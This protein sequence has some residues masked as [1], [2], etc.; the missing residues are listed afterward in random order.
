MET[1]PTF[2]IFCESVLFLVGVIVFCW[3]KR[4]PGRGNWLVWSGLIVLLTG[5]GIDSGLLLKEPF[6]VKMWMSGWIWARDE[7]GAITVGVLQDALGLAMSVLAALVSG[8][9]L[10]SNPFLA[11]E[12]LPERAYAGVAIST[13]G[14]GVAWCSLTPWLCFGGMILTFLGGF[15]VLG[16]RWH[17]NS[18]SDLTARFVRERFIGFL[19]SFFGACILGTTRTALLLNSAEILNAQASNMNSTWIGS[20]L[21]VTGLFIQMQPFPFFGWIVSDLKV[22][23]PLKVILNQI[24]PAWAAFA[25]LVRLEP[26]LVTLGLFPQFGWFAL[27]SCLFIVASGLFQ[28]KWHVG[29]S[30]WLA[31]GLSLSCAV[32][33]FTGPLSAMGLMVGVSLGALCLSCA[34]FSFDQEGAQVEGSNRTRTRWVRVAAFLGAASGTGVIGFVSATGSVRWILQSLDSSPI[35]AF[36]LLVFFLF[37]LLG[38]KQLWSLFRHP[39]ETNMPWFSILSLYLWIFLA[40]GVLWTGA[41]TGNVLLIPQDRIIPS[42]YEEIFGPASA[43]FANTANFIPASSLYWGVLILAIATAYWTSGRKENKWQTLANWMP[44]SSSFMARGF[45]VDPLV[46]KSMSGM[47]WFGSS[48]ERMVDQKVWAEWIPKFLFFGIKSLSKFVSEMDIRLTRGLNGVLK[49]SVEIPAK[50]LQLIQTGDLRWYLFFSLGS[51]FA[52]L[53]HFLKL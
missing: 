7:V 38:W 5:I 12:P 45:G 40:L 10:V 34:S 13:V 49:K 17:E 4:M 46:Q 39:N 31:A 15:V 32:L 50:V 8:A 22:S 36:F 41:L 16:S 24:F 26:Q 27:F 47:V 35:A 33:A 48:A 3:G 28:N 29:L 9:L 21:L 11:R 19:L 2:F 25:I 1:T 53:S 18:E 14:V 37:V 6:K 20:I 23:P 51:G 42:F 43:E 52:L 30:A 44:R